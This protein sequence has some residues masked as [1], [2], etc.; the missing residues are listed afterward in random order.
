MGVCE[1]G[2]VGSFFELNC[3][4]KHAIGVIRDHDVELLIGEEWVIF[5]NHIPKSRFLSYYFY[6][7]GCE[8]VDSH[9]FDFLLAQQH[10][11]LHSQCRKAFDLLPHVVLP[12][13]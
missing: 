5:G 9:F 8:I 2:L 1:D 11:A 10:S 7:E 4:K 13:G 12:I 6:F 3:T